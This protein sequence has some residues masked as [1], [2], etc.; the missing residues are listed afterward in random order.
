MQ[1]TEL[2]LEISADKGRLD[3]PLIHRFLSEEAYWCRG[4]P[5]ATLQ[6]AINHS[7]CFGGYLGAQQVA[8]ARVITDK[9]TFGYL[10]DVFVLPEHRGRGYSKALVAA[11]L[12]H[13]EL[14]GLR[15]LSLATSDAHGLYAGFG[16]VPPASPGSLMEIYHPDIYQRT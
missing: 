2:A 14:Q 3:V 9:A 6:R 7:L 1:T 15:R 16:F 13:P 5:L 12:D 8:F 11:M 4:I 10:A